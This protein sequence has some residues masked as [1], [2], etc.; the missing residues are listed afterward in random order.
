MMAG[1]T[2]HEKGR[3]LALIVLVSFVA[4]MAGYGV[5]IAFDSVT[6]GVLLT[7]VIFF[8]FL[9]WQFYQLVKLSRDDHQSVNR[10]K[11]EHATS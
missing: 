10:E 5:T 3:F 7:L 4:V 2:W 11:G 9:G 1:T 8:G 6:L